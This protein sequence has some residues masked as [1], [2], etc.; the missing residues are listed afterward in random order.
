MPKFRQ[1]FKNVRK[2]E[3]AVSEIR[4][5]FQDKMCIKTSVQW[6]PVLTVF[7]RTCSGHYDSRL[8]KLIKIKKSEN[9]GLWLDLTI[10]S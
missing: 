4:T 3:F 9:Q 1:F 2:E 10:V 8:K 5:V 6:K 7:G